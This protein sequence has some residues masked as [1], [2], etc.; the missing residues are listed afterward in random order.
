MLTARGIGDH[1]AFDNIEAYDDAKDIIRLALDSEDN[2]NLLLIGPH[3]CSKKLFLT[4]T[5]KK[6]A[7]TS[8][9]IIVRIALRRYYCL[10]KKTKWLSY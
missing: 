3:A 9:G 2:Y 5:A 6:A 10:L 7:F 8:M 1:E 4:G